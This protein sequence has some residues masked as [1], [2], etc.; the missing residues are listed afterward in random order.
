MPPRG[1]HVRD[2]AG[3]PWSLLIALLSWLPAIAVPP[4]ID[5]GNAEDGRTL[6]SSSEAIAARTLGELRAS[7]FT[8]NRG[9]LHHPGIRFYAASRNFQV[10]FADGA[11]L[12]TIVETAP[13]PS[14]DDQRP[15]IRAAQPYPEPARLRG[16]ML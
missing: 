11:V 9:Q 1:H 6:A 14:R 10:G 2:T 12:L 15:T 7:S 3:G 4:A 16:V 5:Q 13:A 8:E